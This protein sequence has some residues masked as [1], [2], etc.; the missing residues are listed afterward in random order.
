MFVSARISFIFQRKMRMKKIIAKKL[1]ITVK[2]KSY[3]ENIG[4][5]INSELCSNNRLKIRISIGT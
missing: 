3:V 5:I 1:K 2:K 4:S